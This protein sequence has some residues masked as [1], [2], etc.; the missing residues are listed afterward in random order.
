MYTV[1]DENKEIYNL[2]EGKMINRGTIQLGTLL[3][4]IFDN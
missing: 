2:H 3:Y 1:N 4:N